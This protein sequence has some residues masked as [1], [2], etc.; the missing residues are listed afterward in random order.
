MHDYTFAPLCV[1]VCMCQ[2]HRF[3][4][5]LDSS[6]EFFAVAAAQGS[7]SHAPASRPSLE[8]TALLTLLEIA[9]WL[10]LLEITAL[11]TLWCVLH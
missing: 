1:P 5:D 7:A 11:L 8:M 10:T 2:M 3:V 6:W 4:T 9:A